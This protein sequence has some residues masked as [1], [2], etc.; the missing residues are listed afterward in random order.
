[1]SGRARSK[2]LQAA[3]RALALGLLLL[4]SAP[5]LPAAAAESRSV[6][7]QDGWWNRL[8]GPVE[9]EPDG[10]PVRPLVPAVPKPPSVPANAIAAGVTA[11]QVDKVAAVGV[12]VLLDEGTTLDGLVLRLKES[13]ANGAN[14]AADKAR[15]IACPATT[16][17]GP[18]QNAAWRDRPTADC[19]L[20][21]AEGARA[22]DGTWTF[23]LSGIGRL[24]ADPL[25]PLPAYGVVLSIDPASAPSAAQVS[26]VNLDSGGVTVQLAATPAPAR[27]GGESTALRPGSAAAAPPE[28]ATVATSPYSETATGLTTPGFGAAVPVPL[29]G[30][31]PQPSFP[32][33][34][35]SVADSSPP[36][37][38]P[39][40]PAEVTVAA[41]AAA[42]GVAP[43][44]RPAV[45]FWERLPGPTLL[46]IPVAV[47]LAVLVGVVLGP[48]GRPAP[49]LHREGGLSRALARRT[50]AG[51]DAA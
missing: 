26:W 16:P 46:L 19:D 17:W 45:G 2:P 35:P 23:D 24:W 47:G 25:A 11:G 8:Q 32:E 3:G 37:S 9:G 49:V 44:T 27:P 29:S 10:N 14:M 36:G 42:P 50:A 39:E 5:A 4:V 34:A 51:S 48:A 20:G 28:P 31:S 33:A 30:G 1:M 43:Q 6:V 7:T 13:G 12:D 22:G 40:A 38:L 41:P 15:V 18:G 21:S